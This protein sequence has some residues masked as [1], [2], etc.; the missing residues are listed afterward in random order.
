MELLHYSLIPWTHKLMCEHDRYFSLFPP[1]YWRASGGGGDVTE[2]ER[3]GFILHGLTHF[4]VGITKT[5]PSLIGMHCA[6]RPWGKSELSRIYTI[7]FRR[8]QNS[9]LLSGCTIRRST[10]IERVS[11]SSRA[12]VLFMLWMYITPVFI[13]GIFLFLI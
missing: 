1:F 6:S 8:K 11:S 4:I 13:M 10:M 12:I 3:A 7:G 2:Y 9:V 5:F